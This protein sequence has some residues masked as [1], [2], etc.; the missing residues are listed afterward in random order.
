MSQLQKDTN[1]LIIQEKVNR[2]LRLYFHPTKKRYMN[3]SIAVNTGNTEEHESA[4]FKVAFNLM[5]NGHIVITEGTLKNGQRPDIVVLDI[6]EPIAYEICVSES[7]E[8][9]TAKSERYLGMRVIPI[10]IER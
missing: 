3:P 5:K 7:V 1:K 2:N 6:D 9:V 4:K 8:S 10:I